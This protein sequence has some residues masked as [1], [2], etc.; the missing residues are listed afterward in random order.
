MCIL[1]LGIIW[2]AKSFRICKGVHYLYFN[3][4]LTGNAQISL[5]ICVLKR[6]SDLKL[7]LVPLVVLQQCPG[8]H[9]LLGGHGGGRGGGGEDED[10]LHRLNQCTSRGRKYNFKLFHSSSK[11]KTWRKLK[12]KQFDF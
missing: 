3:S 1:Y 4:P 2:H 12:K 5:W 10:Q 6:A 9:G 11:Q 7:F 8:V